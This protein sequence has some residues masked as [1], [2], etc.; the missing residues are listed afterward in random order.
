[1]YSGSSTK[2]LYFQQHFIMDQ[3]LS[4]PLNGWI[5]HVPALIV[6]YVLYEPEDKRRVHPM[7]L[8]VIGSEVILEILTD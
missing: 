2:V 8:P 3:L 4:N 1:M 5:R 6:E 7:S